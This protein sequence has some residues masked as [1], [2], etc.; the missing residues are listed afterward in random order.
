MIV[1]ARI[2]EIFTRLYASQE[3]QTVSYEIRRSDRAMS[4]VQIFPQVSCVSRIRFC[5]GMIQ[6][7]N[8]LE[9]IFGK[10]LINSKKGKTRA[11]PDPEGFGTLI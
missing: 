8:G 2:S 1:L 3:I 5:S 10:C 9:S 6:T 4:N 7:N 11:T